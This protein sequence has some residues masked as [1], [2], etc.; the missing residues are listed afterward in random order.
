VIGAE[1]QQN[2]IERPELASASL[3][4][5]FLDRSPILRRQRLVV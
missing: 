5:G 1:L 2:L 3:F 4:S